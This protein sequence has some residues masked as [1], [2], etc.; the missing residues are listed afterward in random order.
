M[1]FISVA[2]FLMCCTCFAQ[3]SSTFATREEIARD[4][5]P[6]IS[7]LTP[8]IEPRPAALLFQDEEV[9]E[10]KS[11]ALAGLYSILLPG[12]GEL[13]AG[14]YSS[15]K[16]FT[17][18][19]GM[20]WITLGAVHLQANSLQDNA[21]AY[22]VQHAGISPD[23]KD[24]QYFV[25]IGDYNNTNSYNTAVLRAREYFKTYDVQSSYAWQWDVDANRTSYR[26]LR[27]SSDEMYN[28]T[29]FV[30]GVIVL[31]HLVSAINAGRI[32]L[33][34]NK[35]VEHSAVIDL[36]ASLLGTYTHPDGM[37]LTFTKQF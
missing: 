30:V 8:Q 34:H 25:N 1:K 37:M 35:S 13:Y 14:D 32:A 12:M 27:I 16:Y 6:G 28:S 7:G 26:D 18:A 17:I 36:H 5:F 21:R 31:N 11:V 20:L 9:S 15:G 22:A 10:K 3:E 23:N 33:A 29:K 24:D 19:E 2:L 4:L